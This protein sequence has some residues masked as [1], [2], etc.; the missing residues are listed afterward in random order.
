MTASQRHSRSGSIY[1]TGIDNYF[2]GDGKLAFTIA[3]A[4]AGCG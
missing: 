4:G 3:E 1:G 2:T